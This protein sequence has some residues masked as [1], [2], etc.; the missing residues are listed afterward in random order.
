MSNNESIQKH[1]ITLGLTSEELDILGVKGQAQYLRFYHNKR[2]GKSYIYFIGF[3]DDELNELLKVSEE[4]DLIVRKRLDSDLT[5][6]CISEK[7]TPARIKQ[8][9]KYNGLILSKEEFRFV[10]NDAEYDLY[11]NDLIYDSNVEKDFRIAKPLNNFN[12]NLQIASF[13][14]SSEEKYIVNLYEM[15]C[16]CQDFKKKNRN[17]YLKGDIRR[18]CK[19]L[20]YYYKND[21][22]V[23]GLSD[24]NKFIIESGY[25]V[26]RYFN[27]F[28]IENIPLPV[29]VS[30]EEKDDWWNIFM[31]NEKGIYFRY[32]F[33]P[34][35]NRFSYN[36][37]PIGFV[38]ILR[39]KLNDLKDQLDN[40]TDTTQNQSKSRKLVSSN[41]NKFEI[42]NISNQSNINYRTVIGLIIK[43][44]VLGYILYLIF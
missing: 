16:S 41:P 5:F 33:S 36:N 2:W 10:F 1:L 15:T 12:H 22:G 29:I 3:K 38:P 17:D 28:I 26:N 20:I 13:S 23:Y 32:G 19:H 6:I 43:L 44:L 8:A 35:E 24:L 4:N 9:E 31:A 30:Y 25:G 18:L 40:K 11:Y 42:A 21:F 14:H 34:I 27:Y 39:G 7:S 37:K